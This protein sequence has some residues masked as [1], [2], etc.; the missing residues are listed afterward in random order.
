MIENFKLNL[1]KNKLNILNFYLKLLLYSFKYVN[2]YLVLS[3]KKCR[4]H[5]R[6]SKRFVFLGGVRE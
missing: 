6:I 2:Q 5:A 3:K 4:R 1:F